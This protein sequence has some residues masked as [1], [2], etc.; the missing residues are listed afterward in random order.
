MAVFKFVLMIT[1]ITF[2]LISRPAMAS[3]KSYREWKTERIQ[4]AQNKVANLKAQI[5]TKKNQG[6]IAASGTDPN[7]ENK[8]Q[9]EA[10]T[11][12]SMLVEKLEKQLSAEQYD[13]DLA[14]DLSVTD[15]FVGYLIKVQDKKSAFSEVAGRLSP[16]EVAELM[17]AYANVVFGPQAMSESMGAAPSVKPQ[18]K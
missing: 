12:S 6:R 10:G 4:W 13:L 18:K 1:M 17:S 9:T 15:Y 3:V 2:S 8:L 5:E 11:S 14:N 16:D 7:L